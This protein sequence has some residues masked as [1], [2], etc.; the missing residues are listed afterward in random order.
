MIASR[1]TI[2]ALSSG[3]GRAGVAVIRLS[4]PRSGAVL[5][6]LLGRDTMPKPRH[7]IYAPIRDPQSNERLDD[8]VAIY[9]QGPAS[10]TGEDVVELHVHGGRAVIEGVLDCLSRQ[11]GLRVADPGEYTRRAFENGKMDLTSAE[12]IADLIDAETAAQR[13]QAVRQMAGELG[14]L[15]EGWRARLMKAL[16]H[17]EADIDFPDEDL[18]DGIVPVVRGDLMSVFGE[19]KKHLADNRRGERL[20]EGFQIVILGAPNAGKSS[21]LNRLA[22]R[23][24]AIVSEIAGTTRDMIEVH[25]DLGGFPVT[26]VDTAGLRESGDVIESE[27]VR[28]ATERAENADLRLVVIDR[29]D[30]PTIDPEAARLIDD[31]TL[32]LI[33]KVDATDS[34][35]IPASWQGTSVDGRALE[36]P[37]LPIS[38]MTGQGMESLLQLLETRVK[39]GLDFAGPVPLTRLRHR[40]ALESASDHLD[41]G[42]Q[43]DIAEL[44]AEDVRLAVREIGKI[45]GRVDVEDLLDIIFGDFCIG[46]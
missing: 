25:L 20:R 7:A 32:I 30:W 42:L 37:V 28:R 23:D 43:T 3:A 17:I 35:A 38:A 24:A 18:P 5:C 21:L 41:R 34:S 14:T 40:R 26:M 8:A 22:Q 13:R 11:D 10:F 16:A 27:G 33:N 6:A 15:Y 9:F 36:L 29:N 1:E 39:E 44:A 12:G 4:G 45:T 2:F 19:I 46:K 31:K